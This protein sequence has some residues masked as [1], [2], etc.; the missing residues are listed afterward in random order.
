M[1]AHALAIE[2]GH[3]QIAEDIRADLADEAGW[4]A[5][6]RDPGCDIG[7]RA[8]RCQRDPASSI[9]TR[10]QDSIGLGQHIPDQI[11]DSDDRVLRVS[12]Q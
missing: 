3:D 11:A 5:D 8:A 2:I 4:L 1:Y 12:V 10:Q 6:A 7:G 9:A